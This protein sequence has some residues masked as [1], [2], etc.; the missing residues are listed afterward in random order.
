MHN[1]CSCEPIPNTSFPSSQ[2]DSSSSLVAQIKELRKLSASNAERITKL[3]KKLNGL[4]L[5]LTLSKETQQR[6]QHSRR[7]RDLNM[8]LLVSLLKDRDE[9]D[10]KV[11]RSEKKIQAIRNLFE[12]LAEMEQLKM[13]L[14]YENMRSLY[15]IGELRMENATLE[16]TKNDLLTRCKYTNSSGV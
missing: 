5:A 13:D 11:G 6:L 15:S 1:T 4:R 14:E 7:M 12:R 10:G 16:Q 9:K 2:R 8:R 3:S